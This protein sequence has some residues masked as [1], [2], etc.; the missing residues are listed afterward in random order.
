MLHEVPIFMGVQNAGFHSM[1]C[2]QHPLKK[3]AVSYKNVWL[4]TVCC[5][6]T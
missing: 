6:A 4:V 3:V 1:L 2:K 5:N